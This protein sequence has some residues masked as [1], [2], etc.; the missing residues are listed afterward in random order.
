MN[1]FA[2]RNKLEKDYFEGWYMRFTDRSHKIQYAIIFAVT[3]ESSDPHSFIQVY[4]G[5][6]LTNEYYRFEVG[7]FSYSNEIVKIKDN[8]LSKDSIYINLGDLEVDLK[9]KKQSYLLGKNNNSAMSFLVHFPLECFQDVIYM[10]ALF[11]GEI[12]SKDIVVQTSG[13]AYMEKT[14]GNRFPK[15][16]MWLQ[17]NHFDEDVSFSFA[18]GIIPVLK[19]S[20]KGFFSILRY[21]GNELR[22]ASYN[23]SRLKVTNKSNSKLEFIIRKG[24]YRLSVSADIIDNV[25]LVGPSDNGLMNLDVFESINSKMKLK[26]TKGKT[27]IFDTIGSD[28][29]LENMFND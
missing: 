5:S 15:K 26:L 17:C 29:G 10:D 19:F 6:K 18:H 16:W 3:K 2:F 7:D 27:V 1:T 21:K 20:K 9:V 4:D 14:Y 22:F 8:Y 12:K 23:L 25:L 24:R 28:V 11:Q 13:K